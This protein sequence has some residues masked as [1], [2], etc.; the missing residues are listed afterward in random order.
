MLNFMNVVR[1]WKIFLAIGCALSAPG[2]AIGLGW[3]APRFSLLVTPARYNVLQVAFDTLS[4]CNVV[5]VAYQ[6]DATRRTPIL[7]VWNGLEWLALSMDDFRKMNFLKDVPSQ[8]IL[9]GDDQTLPVELVESSMM[10][11]RGRVMQIP[12]QDSAT[13]INSLGQVFDFRKKDWSWYAARYQLDLSDANAE[14]RQHSWYDR[15]NRYLDESMDEEVRGNTSTT[16]YSESSTM[17]ED[18]VIEGDL[19]IRERVTTEDDVK[20]PPF[21]SSSE[22]WQETDVGAAASPIK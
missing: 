11:K 9:V 4:R 15:P 8:I 5:L 21:T 3:S 19:S 2:I 6:E 17:D 20:I 7:H 1:R 16:P 13:L 22:S 14:L 10:G 18:T 12:S